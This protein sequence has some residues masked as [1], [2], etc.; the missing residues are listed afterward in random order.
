[1]SNKGQILIADDDA[2]CR[3]VL[4]EMLGY[5]DYACTCVGD[6]AE[7]AELLG[8]EHFDVFICDINMPG[9]RNL[10]LIRNLPESA[11]GLPVIL[12]TG[13]PS[14]ETAISSVHLSV[15][16]YLV[17]P[18]KRQDLLDHVAKL[19]EYSRVCRSGK[20]VYERLNG[21]THEIKELRQYLIKNPRMKEHFPVGDFVSLTVSNMLGS[22]LDLK[23]LVE[24]LS[25]QKSSQEVCQLYDCPRLEQYRKII[26]DTI[27]VL[28]RTRSSFKSKELS[29]LRHT[30]EQIVQNDSPCNK[31]Y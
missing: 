6:G 31:N 22:I 14:L 17:K 13:Y 18:V 30:L 19:T 16:A 12:M 9:N 7:A 20:E 3:K 8:K 28:E 15:M 10:E 1:M 21:W 25:D 4:A 23:R 2:S 24:G 26:L 11:A 27:K 5:E 29:D